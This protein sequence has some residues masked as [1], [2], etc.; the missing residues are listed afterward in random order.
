MAW[1]RACSRGTTRLPTYPVTPATKTFWAAPWQAGRSWRPRAGG[2][3]ASTAMSA[4]RAAVD[5]GRP[6]QTSRC[7]IACRTALAG[8]HPRRVDLDLLTVV[9]A[10]AREGHVGRVAK[11]PSLGRSAASHAL[12]R[13]RH[14]P[15]DPPFVRWPYGNRPAARAEALAAAL[16]L[17][18][19]DIRATP[20]PAA[21]F[22]PGTVRRRLSIGATDDASFVVLPRPIPHRRQ[23]A[24][25]MDVQV[26]PTDQAS[27][28][29]GARPAG[30]RHG[31]RTSGPIDQPDG[32]TR[33]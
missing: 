17:I 9:E 4:S 3:P 11:R 26:G 8:N 29:G 33:R 18:L 32:V 22:D 10:L 1:P 14:V 20:T 13:L 31:Q 5:A 21:P 30:R 7:S 28:L 24:P 2:A 19:R 27:I 23:V 25:H 15:D 6:T 16:A 12:G